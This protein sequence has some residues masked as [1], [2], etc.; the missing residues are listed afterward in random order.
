[1]FTYGADRCRLVDINCN[2]LYSMGYN[3]FSQFLKEEILQLNCLNVMWTSFLDD[4]KTYIDLTPRNFHRFI[5]LASS[6]FKAALPKINIMM[7]GTRMVNSDSEK[8]GTASKRS[9]LSDS[10]EHSQHTY[11]SPVEWDYIQIKKREVQSKKQT[12]TFLST[13]KVWPVVEGI[14]SGSCRVY[15]HK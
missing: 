11:R 10:G 6:S 9:L 5:R 3:E 8:K 7:K 14:Q 1:M 12:W 4:E 13:T 15:W 2:D